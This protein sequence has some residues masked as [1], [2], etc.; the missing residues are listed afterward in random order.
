MDSF[1][2][3]WHHFS[4][5]LRAYGA[6]TNHEPYAWV[7][8]IATVCSCICYIPQIHR[9]RKTRSAKDISY[10]MFLIW[11]FGSTLWLVY[12]LRT[13]KGPVILTNFINLSFRLWVLFYK[14]IADRRQD[15]IQKE[16]N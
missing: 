14:I 1:S 3:M 6:Q 5:T 16:K 9:I 11:I 2:S 4:E 10:A 7:G 13:H 15:N 12:G 8:Y